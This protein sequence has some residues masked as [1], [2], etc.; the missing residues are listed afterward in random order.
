MSGDA[1]AGEEL[2]AGLERRDDG[3]LELLAPA[4][5]SWWHP[6]AAGT[7]VGPGSAIGTLWR[8]GRAARL[9]VP[10]GVAGRVVDVPDGRL[11]AVGWGD[12]LLR[13]APL[14]AGADAARGP[15]A[16]SGESLDELPA[17]CH[18]VTAPTAGVFYRRPSPGAAPFVE[19]GGRV[20]RGQP[21][22]LVEVMKTFNQIVWDGAGSAEE[23]EVVELRAENG[24]DVRGGQVLVV[25]RGV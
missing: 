21:V 23:A 18:A 16:A 25:L 7:I 15:D 22:G 20:R 10:R 3:T 4:V 2:E 19:V 14:D 13:L 6:P 12:P 1:R 11:V 9:C 5:G 17:G 24:G 8:L